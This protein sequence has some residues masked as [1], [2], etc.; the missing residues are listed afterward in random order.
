MELDPQLR[1]EVRDNM[2][3]EAEN[4]NWNACPACGSTQIEGGSVS[5]ED[6]EAIQEVSCLYCKAVWTEVYEA[7]SRTDIHSP[8]KMFEVSFRFFTREDMDNATVSSRIKAALNHTMLQEP[9]DGWKY[10]KVIG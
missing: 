9:Y 5:I 1:V 6:R 4:T 8:E 3:I 2:T 7:A 10:L